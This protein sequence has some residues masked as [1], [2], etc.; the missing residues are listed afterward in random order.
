[1]LYLRKTKEKWRYKKIEKWLAPMDLLKAVQANNNMNN[2]RVNYLV[3]LI[4]WNNKGILYNSVFRF[5]E[6]D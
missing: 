1:M 3:K 6:I 4:N 2:Y 5:I